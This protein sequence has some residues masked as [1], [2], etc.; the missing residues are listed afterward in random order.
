MASVYLAIAERDAESDAD[1]ASLALRRAERLDPQGPTQPRAQSLR[2]TLDARR[3]L[4]RGIV[5]EALVRRALELDPT[6]QRAEALL[7]QLLL[8]PEPSRLRTNRYLGAA[9]IAALGVLWLL[10]MGLRQRRAQR[11]N[12]TAAEG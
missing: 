9:V 8:D 12:A 7:A 6:N 5:D 3:L 2:H 11:A 10:L 1:A 4:A